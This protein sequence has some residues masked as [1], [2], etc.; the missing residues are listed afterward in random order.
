MFMYRFVF[1][2]TWQGG[3]PQGD[4]HCL[5]FLTLH[6]LSFHLHHVQLVCG[7]GVHTGLREGGQ[8]KTVNLQGPVCSQ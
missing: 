5:D 4:Q 3:G 2:Y 6:V 1:T 7:A 8:Q